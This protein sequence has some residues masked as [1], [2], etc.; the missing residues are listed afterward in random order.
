MPTPI[1]ISNGYF[2]KSSKPTVI[3]VGRWDRRKRPEIFFELARKFP[4][5]IFIAAG[6]S[7]DKARD[8]VLRNQYGGLHNLKM[9]G[10][11]DQFSGNHL[12]KLYEKSWILVNTSTRE[13]LP[14]AF[15]EAMAHKC[16]IVSHVNPENT[17]SRFGYHV[18]DGNFEKGLT[19]LL[20]NSRWIKKGEAGSVYV[21]EN[22]DFKKAIDA[23]INVYENLLK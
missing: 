13:G 14:N 8:Q 10:L 16:A 17:A 7:Q 19:S 1:T 2:Q 6:E 18:K 9:P 20:L 12:A 22:Y 21:K 4:D 5:V 3:L 15:L 23:H 11:L